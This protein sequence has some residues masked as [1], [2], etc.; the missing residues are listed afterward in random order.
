MPKNTPTINRNQVAERV[1]RQNVRV[2][3]DHPFWSSL[4]LQMGIEQSDHIPTACTDGTKIYYNPAYYDGLTDQQ[5]FTVQVHEV[6]HPALGHL[7][8]K[9]DREMEK[10]NMACDYE[11]NNF[12]MEYNDE[13]V[14]SGRLAP[15]DFPDGALIDP[16]F[17]GKSAEEIYNL[18]PDPPK[19]PGGKPGDGEPGD[20]PGQPGDQPG[21]PGDQ[22]GDQ[23]GQPGNQPGP[24]GMGDFT[25]PAKADG[26]SEAEWKNRIAQAHNAAKLQGRGSGSMGRLVDRI[27]KGEQDWRYILRDLLSSV[28]ADDYDEQ[29]PDRRFLEDDIYLPSLYSEKV[30][31]FVVAIDTS[32]SVSNDM[33]RKFMG[34]VQVCLDTVKPEK[35]TVID[36]DA[37]IYQVVEFAEGDDVES[38]S[39]N[40]GGGTDFNPVFDHVRKLDSQPEAVVYFTDGMGDFPSEAPP[41]P[42]IWVDYGGTDYPFGEVVRV[43]SSA[44]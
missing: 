43:N 36:C 25:D 31:E 8:R 3:V 37:K 9:G 30:G 2:V 19:P 13:E 16:A 26:N 29:R 21:Q 40:G 28:A 32:G 15:F 44:A 41:Y 38:F 5:I 33:L 10:W 24:G 17:K 1:E 39:P 34:E 18:I 23:P 27:L 12:L 6:G 35:I 11:L 7:W 4:L 42:V 22:P 20:G 14:A